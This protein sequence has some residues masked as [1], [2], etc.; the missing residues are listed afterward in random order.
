VETL[1]AELKR[2]VGW[3][4]QDE[5][6]LRELHAHAVPAF[7][8]I[9]DAHYDRILFHEEA[10]T[11]LVGGE[12]RVGQLKVQLIAWMDRLL[13]GP[14]TKTIFSC[15]AASAARTCASRFRNITCSDR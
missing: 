8:R 10:R 5:L 11:A 14:G 9:A 1:F 3:E 7:S 6:R 12:S 13:S 2:Y 4:A 15:A